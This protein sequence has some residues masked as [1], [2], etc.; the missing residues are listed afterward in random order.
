MHNAA[1]RY[2]SASGLDLSADYTHYSSWQLA[3]MRNRYADGNRTAFDV[4]SGQSV[5]RVNVSADQSHDLGNGWGMTYG[6]IFSWA[7]DHDYQRYRLHE[8][9]IAT[10]DTDSHLD[11]YTG[12]LY[13]GVSKQFAKGEFLAVAGRGIL[14][15]GGLRQLVA[16]PAGDPAPDTRRETSRTDFALVGQDLSLVLGDAAV[17][18]LHRR[19]F[20]DPGHARTAA[21]EKL[22]RPG[23]VHV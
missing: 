20:G 13:A 10:V 2:T 14:P 1:L 7:G 11:E 16:L 8:G 9:D 21:V 19:L 22:Q 23:N 15:R 12:N 5:D 3:A 18:L 6:G 17:D 4:V